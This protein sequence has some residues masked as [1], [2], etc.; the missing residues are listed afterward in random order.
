MHFPIAALALGLLPFAL[1]HPVEKR[2]NALP[3]VKSGM[4]K[5]V[6]QLALYLEHL[7]MSL[8]TGGFNNFTDTQYTAEGFPAGFRENVGVIAEHEATHAQ[9]ISTILSDAGYTPVPPCTYKFPYMDPTSF[10]DLANMITSVGIGAYLGG[11]SLLTDDPDLLTAASSILTVESRHDAYLRAGVG[12]SP[13]PTAF[14]TALTALFA[15]NLA[16]MFIVSC[17]QQLPIVLLPKL[18]LVSPMPKSD[19]QPPT[20]AGT[21][22]TFNFDPATF[23]VKVDPNAQLY[24]GMVNMVTNVTFVEATSCGTGCVTAPVP[25]GAAGAAFAVLSTF[26]GGLNLNQ[27]SE[28]G[29][30]AGPAEVVLS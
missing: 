19:L 2:Q 24:I 13:Y 7:E 20:P 30:L 17:P 18:T 29:A 5:S 21:V 9:T 28:F 15:Y 10:V 3:P 16:Q 25:E 4:D 8:Y 14:D 12:A 11:A 22:L 23:F 6:L 27:I 26:S 1:S